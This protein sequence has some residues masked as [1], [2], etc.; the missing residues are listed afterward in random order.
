[1]YTAIT[2]AGNAYFSGLKNLS[3][4]RA[5]KLYTGE[6][7]HSH[8][9]SGTVAENQLND[10]ISVRFQES[11]PHSFYDWHNAPAEQYVICL[12]G[13]L[14]FETRLGEK[15]V[16]KPGEVLI[17]LDTQGSAHKWRII[18]DQPWKRAYVAFEK[19]AVINFVADK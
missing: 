5:Y 8:F 3:M 17:A 2:F 6:D 10:A 1:L 19:G 18:D 9:I 16:L 14:E 11:P 15:F 13:T 4:I 12:T 7:N